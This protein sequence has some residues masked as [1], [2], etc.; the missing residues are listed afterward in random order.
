MNHSFLVSF[1]SYQKKFLTRKLKE[2]YPCESADSKNS[3]DLRLQVDASA[4]HTSLP[5]TSVYTRVSTL[6]STL[7][8]RRLLVSKYRTIS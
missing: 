8:D 3:V 6:L 4:D 1:S 2:Y 5:V 7:L